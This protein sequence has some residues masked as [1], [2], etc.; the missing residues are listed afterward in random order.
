MGG[1]DDKEVDNGDDD[2]EEGVGVDKIFRDP[3]GPPP[4]PPPTPLPVLL[5][6]VG[7]DT[8][9]MMVCDGGVIGELWAWAA[10]LSVFGTGLLG[11]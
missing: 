9:G 7:G 5:L 2:D 8:L 11:P 6:L 10:G 3:A 4:P 1:V